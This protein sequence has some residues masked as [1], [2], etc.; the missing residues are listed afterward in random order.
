MANILALFISFNIT[1]VITFVITGS[2][3]IYKNRDEFKKS[4]ENRGGKV[5]GS[6]TK[7]TG[8]LVINDFNSNSSKAKKARDLG[9]DLI[10]EKGFIE[11][12]GK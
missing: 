12:F 2:V 5:T 1:F 10:T 6:V 11:K 4:V 8:F 9:I 7:N 3:F